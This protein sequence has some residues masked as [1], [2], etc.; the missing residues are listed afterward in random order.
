MASHLLNDINRAVLD[1]FVAAWGQKNL[2][3]LMAC[4][5]DDFVYRASIGPE[6]GTTYDGRA[7]VRAGVQTMWAAD[8]GS[9]AQ[10]THIAIFGDQGWIEW[11]YRWPQTSGQ[12]HDEIGCDLIRFRDGRLISKDAY[13]KV[14]PSSA[15]TPSVQPQPVAMPQTGVALTGVGYSTRYANA[16]DAP[17]L[18]ALMHQL[19]E[20]EGYAD[21]MT[22]TENDLIERGL[23][24]QSLGHFSAI[25]AQSDLGEL[26]G[27]AVVYSI[28]FTYDLR[29]TLV[30][31][32]FLV[33]ESARGTGV[34]RNLFRHVVDHA[35]AH[36]CRL[37]KWDVLPNNERAKAFYRSC[38]GEHDVDWDNW[39]MRV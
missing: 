26:W 2:D 3:A 12:H 10:I 25:V 6:P 8:A 21:R 31:K 28:P 23:G 17:H 36:H 11:I 4:V 37:L 32:E 5:T 9:Q 14:L 1:R 35:K 7:A 19:A 38:G 30:L 27:Y 20:F 15:T 22:V 33:T 39:I 29:P 18:M 16:Q 24:A 34:G 13:R